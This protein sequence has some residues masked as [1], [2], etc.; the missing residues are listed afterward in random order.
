MRTLAL[1]ARQVAYENRSFWRNPA[2]AFFT[3]VFPLMFL[4]IFPLVFGSGTINYFGQETSTVTFYVPAIA[5]FSVITACYTNLAMSITFSREEGVLKRKRGTPLPAVSFLGARIIHS[6]FIAIVLVAI[7]VL[8]GVLFY[9]VDLPVNTLPAFFVTLVVGA[10]SFCALGLAITGFV[11]NADAAPAVINFSILPLLF[12]SD[13][14]IP[15]QDAPPWLQTF[16]GV[17]PL[18]HFSHAMLAAF[19]PFE[20]G[21]GFSWGDLAIV[22]A[23]GVAGVV[24]AL[25]FFTWEPK[26]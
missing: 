26:R 17:F 15:I 25:R 9:N 10:A 16:S 23:W 24:I 6:T 14:F 1:T 11:P 20:T 12:I 5:A 22:A 2:A 13:V 18:R 21:A 8:T 7:V 4:V 19:N 3:F